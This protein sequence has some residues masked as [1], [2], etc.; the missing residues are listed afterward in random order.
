MTRMSARALLKETLYGAAHAV[1]LPSI[2][3]RRQRD[4]LIVLTYHSFGPAEEHPYLTRLPVEQLER[5]LGHLQR[6]Y[7][8]VSLEEGIARLARDDTGPPM[9][10]LTVDDGYSDNFTHLFPLVRR[11]GVPVTIFLATDYLDSGRLPWPTRVS[12][13]LHFATRTSLSEPVR[14]SL[15]TPVER[16]AAGRILRQTLSRMSHAQREELLLA[17]T[18]ALQPRMHETLAP[19]TWHQVRKMSAAGVGFGAHTHYHG[20][21]N[22]IGA[23]E[24][25]EELRHSRQRIEDETRQP[26]RA[27]AYPN[28]NWSEA[29]V[30][31]ASSA[32]YELA[33]TQQPG[34]NRKND[35]QPLALRRLQVPE[36]ERIGTFACRVGGIAV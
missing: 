13:L 6:H 8:I 26:C 33:L 14:L 4:G 3:R 18:D 30:A 9:V 34:L 1:G 15:T 22:C 28:G 32:G 29:V 25:D 5:Q 17:L 31:A 16:L 27:L 23:D 7:R 19:L 12:A 20:W 21:L 10:V 24:V 36:D 11:A 2:G 35:L